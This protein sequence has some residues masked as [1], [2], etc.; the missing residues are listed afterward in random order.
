MDNKQCEVCKKE[1]GNLASLRWHF[2]SVHKG[3]TKHKCSLC[4]YET[5]YSNGLEIHYR[6]V[7]EKK[8]Q[9][10]PKRKKAFQDTS[11]LLSCD[12][13]E[14]TSMFSAQ[15]K[16]HIKSVHDKIR[17]VICEICHFA[18]TQKSILVK[19]MR[20]K[21]GKTVNSQPINIKTSPGSS[22]TYHF[23]KIKSNDGKSFDIKQLD[24]QQLDVKKEVSNSKINEQ[25]NLPVIIQSVSQEDLGSITTNC[26]ER[27]E[28][29]VLVPNIP[30]LDTN[31]T[32][33]K[34]ITNNCDEKTLVHKIANAVEETQKPSEE[35]PSSISII[36]VNTKRI[37]NKLTC[38]E[39]PYTTT[40]KSSLKRH[41]RENHEGVED[42]RC[43]H[44][45]YTTK[46][47]AFLERHVK[48][49]HDQKKD[50][51]CN[52]CGYKSDQLTNLKKHIKSVHEKVRDRKCDIC[53]YATGDKST[54]NRHMEK[55]NGNPNQVDCKVC[56]KTFKSEGILKAHNRAFHSNAPKHKCSFCEY[57][58][59]QMSGMKQ[60]IKAIHHKIKD[61]VCKICDFSTPH[62]SVLVKHIRRA[63][64][65]VS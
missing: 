37:N 54:L 61:K 40:T 43:T 49:V 42:K 55:H 44:C 14:F 63:H 7:H 34:E 59:V 25:G 31:N 11:K 24:K 17:D 39:C 2:R 38:D 23:S 13:C 41:I 29:N 48:L 57:E 35:E 46:H 16:V 53:G 56:Q 15:L 20:R 22:I 19:H 12:H 3:E 65:D 10:A 21:H 36:N 33:D 18:T 60:H 1:F 8:S 45:D 50:Y 28:E 4:K 64:S 47:D 30:K 52:K 27:C 9:K 6:S 26:K 58:C 51:V 5:I 32:S 62:T